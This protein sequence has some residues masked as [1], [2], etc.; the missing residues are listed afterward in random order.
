M[1][2]SSKGPQQFYHKEYIFIAWSY[3]Q[4]TMA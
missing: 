2:S 1:S 3:D 4:A